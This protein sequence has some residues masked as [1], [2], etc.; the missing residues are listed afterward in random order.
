MRE[1]QI[2]KKVKS[3]FHEQLRH[4]RIVAWSA[5]L[6]HAELSAGQSTHEKQ[7]ANTYNDSMFRSLFGSAT[8]DFWGQRILGSEISGV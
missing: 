8:L 2:S 4:C 1:P 6:G 5:S 7:Q 3:K